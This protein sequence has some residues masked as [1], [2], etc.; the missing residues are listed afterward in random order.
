MKKLPYKTCFVVVKFNGSVNK[1]F[2]GEVEN[3][4]GYSEFS[5]DNHLKFIAKNAL[6]DDDDSDNLFILC[7]ELYLN[8]KEAINYFKKDAKKKCFLK[9]EM[10]AFL[11]FDIVVDD[12]GLTIEI[13]VNAYDENRGAFNDIAELVS[14]ETMKDFV[15]GLSVEQQD[16]LFEIV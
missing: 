1:L 14:H 16:L 7:C 8:S 12:S 13:S 11:V 3:Q 2:F 10:C 5:F 4:D 15:D 6:D 9:S